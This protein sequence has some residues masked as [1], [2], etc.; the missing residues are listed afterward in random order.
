MACFAEEMRRGQG[1]LL[2]W[3]MLWPW[4]GSALQ[5]PQLQGLLPWKAAQQFQL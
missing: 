5:S 3:Q 4:G 1:L 2:A